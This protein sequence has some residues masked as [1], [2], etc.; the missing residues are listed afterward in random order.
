[1]L[2]PKRPRFAQPVPAGMRPRVRRR[3]SRRFFLLLLLLRVAPSLDVRRR[4][5]RESAP[6]PVL[7][8]SASQLSVGSC[9]LSARK[10]GVASR[11]S[12]PRQ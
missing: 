6:L 7:A 5:A 1:M 12:V 10:S 3:T 2:E 9:Q 8:P 4:I 11:Q